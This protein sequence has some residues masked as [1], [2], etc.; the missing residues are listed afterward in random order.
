LL[1]PLLNSKTTGITEHALLVT[2]EK[3]AS[4]H[5]VDPAAVVSM[6]WIKPSASSTPMCIFT[7]KYH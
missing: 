1:I 5:G 7:P 6:L 2:V 4:G 3:V